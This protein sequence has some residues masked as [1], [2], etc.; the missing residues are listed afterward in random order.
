MTLAQVMV[1]LPGVDVDAIDDY[2][3]EMRRRGLAAGTISKRQRCLEML[4]DEHPL[5]VVTSEE[6]QAFL[7]RRDLNARSRYGW[8][9]HL[10]MFFEWATANEHVERNPTARLTRPKM[11][12]LVPD[13]TPEH[14]V[15][16][17][18]ENGTPLLAAWVT[19]M[20]Y[21][22]LRCC[23]VAS[24]RGEY[25]DR[26]A[27]TLRVVGKG[28]KPRVIPMHP[29]V[30][31]V[32]VDAPFV[33]TVFINSA[34]GTA[35]APQQVSRFVGMHLRACGC[36]HKR[37]HRLRHRFASQLLESGADIATVGELLGHESLDT[38]RSYAAV[39]MRRMREAVRLI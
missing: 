9:S 30:A 20:A 16:A 28:D 15:D 26:A 10:S 18:I 1:R 6:I 17:A 25:I 7:D 3:L 35:F 37:A 32:L 2:V 21:A 24:L 13:P 38:T 29:K 31:A 39:S 12:R 34:T 33:G 5:D 8:L 36:T 22:G 14:E 27:G 23:E 4:D 11:R 19:L